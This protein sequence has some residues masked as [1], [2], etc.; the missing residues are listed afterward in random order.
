MAFKGNGKNSLSKKDWPSELKAFLL[1]S[2]GKDILTYM[3]VDLSAYTK[4]E[5]SELQ[6]WTGQDM[7]FDFYRLRNADKL[8]FEDIGSIR[9][10]SYKLVID[11]ILSQKLFKNEERIILDDLK[12]FAA[13]FSAF[14]NGAPI[15]KLRINLETGKVLEE[16]Y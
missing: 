4:D 15:D 1:K 9:I 6:S 3:D 11:S 7:I 5:L 13:I 10:Q 16:V 8:A 2:S 14:K 12:E